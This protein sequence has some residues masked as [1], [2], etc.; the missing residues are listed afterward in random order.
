MELARNKEKL[1]GT[2]EENKKIKNALSDKDEEISE[3]Q[4]RVTRLN[5]VK[6]FYLNKC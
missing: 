6:L 5:T 1:Q 3:L 2:Q 4:K